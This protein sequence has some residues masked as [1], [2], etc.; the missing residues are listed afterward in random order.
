M[1]WERLFADIESQWRAAEEAE[2]A[3]EVAD[4]A[5]REAATLH[6]A[7]RVRGAVGA[8]VQVGL[9]GL[10]V[11]NGRLTD[12]GSQWLLVTEP[13]GAE[14]WAP[15]SGVAWIAGLTAYSEA[16]TGVVASRLGMT[17]ALRAMARD[18]SAVTVWLRDGTSLPG[19]I[20]RVGADFIELRGDVA[21]ELPRR[22]RASVRTV[23]TA[24]IVAIRRGA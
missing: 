5:R 7:D 13:A 4:R 12:C 22:D 16:P 2:F 19:V 9:P 14:V 23:A 20:D 21:G 15:L 10:G 3:A 6:L 1:R 11:V 18:R 8:Q 24:A 17:S